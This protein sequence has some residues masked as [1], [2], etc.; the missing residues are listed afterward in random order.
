MESLRIYLEAG[1]RWVFASALDWPGWAR[2]GK[3]DEAAIDT[4]LDYA[5]RY[6]KAVGRVVSTGPVEVVGRLATRGGMAD[7]GALG[8]VGPWDSEPLAAKELTRQLELLEA[9]WDYL[10]AVGAAS[11]AE[12]RKGQR[13]GGRDTD[14]M[15]RHVQEAERSYAAKLGGR[16]PPRT[17]WPQQRTTILAGLRTAPPDSAWPVRYG[18][19]RLAWHVLD[20]AWEMQDRST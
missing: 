3:G 7:F 10:D 6:A 12:L 5:E 20:H 1:T 18:I 4:L 19:R 13:G 8:A 17:P 2:R 16:V 14:A 15:L 9:S 11:P